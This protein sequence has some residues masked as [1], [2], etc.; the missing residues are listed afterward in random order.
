MTTVLI[1]GTRKWPESDADRVEEM[2]NYLDSEML[3]TKVVVGGAKGID[4]I[5]ENWARKRNKEVE[6]Y[7]AQ[8]DK[9]G[10][11]AGPR[12]NSQ[13]LEEGQPHLVVAFPDL[14]GGKDTQDMIKKAEAA[15]IPMVVVDNDTDL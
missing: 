12:R 15:D 14:K 8:W 9:Y 10:K 2:L 6:V 3:F 13:M 5:A 11:S 7:P 1:C 4:T